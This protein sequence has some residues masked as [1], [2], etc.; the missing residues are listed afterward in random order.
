MPTYTLGRRQSTPLTDHEVTRLT[1]PL[2][3]SHDDHLPP[4]AVSVLHSPRGGQTTYHGPGQTVLWPV[5][6]LKSAYHKQFTVRCYSRLIEDTT[7][8]VL[9]SLFGLQAFITDDPGV[10]VSKQNPAKIA[11]LGVHLRRHVTALGTA[12]NVAMPGKEVSSE[13]MNP[14]RRIVACGLEGKE[15]TSIAGEVASVNHDAQFG[16]T[17]TEEAVC[18]AW[19]GELARRIDVEGVDTVP[20]ESVV[21][22][23]TDILNGSGDATEE[24]VEYVAWVQRLG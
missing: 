7:I 23:M 21:A 14:W 12:I 8:S 13:E 3:I 15:V 2:R 1:A 5:L 10:W 17:L 19:A 18:A 9:R 24:E 20:R 16:E 22:L 11:A 4:L 6:D